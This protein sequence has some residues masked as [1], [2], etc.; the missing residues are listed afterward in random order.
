MSS[1][2][3]PCSPKGVDLR[4]SDWHLSCLL[5]YE[6]PCLPGVIPAPK[7]GS[8]FSMVGQLG[9]SESLLL[10]F[11][12]S[13]NGLKTKCRIFMVHT[14]SHEVFIPKRLTNPTCKEGLRLKNLLPKLASHIIEMYGALELKVLK[15]C[16]TKKH[17][18]LTQ[19]HHKGY[20]LFKSQPFFRIFLLASFQSSPWHLFMQSFLVS[21]DM[22][23]PQDCTQARQKKM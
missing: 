14:I 7:R 2:T 22:F 23:Q 12:F 15:L 13:K 10:F 11:H 8:F 18:K 19:W 9:W 17:P 20:N 3:I 6:S 1:C 21:F 4:I 16:Q 5:P